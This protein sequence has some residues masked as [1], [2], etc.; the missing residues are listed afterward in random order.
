MEDTN[1]KK[2]GKFAF[3][4]SIGGL[5]LAIL[6]GVVGSLLDK[7]LSM[8]AFL[9]FIGCQIFAFIL[10]LLSSSEKLGKIAIYSSIILSVGSIF[11]LG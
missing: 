2:Y 1:N 4:L 10:G 9:L 5:L 3:L 7:N 8:P 11:L 6:I